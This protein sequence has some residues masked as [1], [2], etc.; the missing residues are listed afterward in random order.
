MRIVCCGRYCFL[1]G[2]SNRRQE[3][4]AQCG[5]SW[6]VLL[7]NVSRLIKSRWM[8]WTSHVAYM[9]QKRHAYRVFGEETEGKRPPGSLG[10][11]GRIILKR[12]LKKLDGR[13][14]RLD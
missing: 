6:L 8:R 9:W 14:N 5:A 1:Q 11:C 7:A 13:T 4:I 12:T 2:G 3:K 10:L